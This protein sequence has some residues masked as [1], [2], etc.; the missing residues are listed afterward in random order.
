MRKISYIVLAFM[1][2][3]GL[4]GCHVTINDLTTSSSVIDY[5]DA[6]KY[7]TIHER[8]SVDQVDSLDVNWV[9]GH[10]YILYSD[11][12]TIEVH[13]NINNKQVEGVYYVDDRTLHIQPCPAGKVQ[14]EAIDKDITI[15]IPQDFVIDAI[16][17]SGVTNDV[18]V[19]HVCVNELEVENVSGTINIYEADVNAAKIET[20]SGNCYMVGSDIKKLEA[21]S[22]SGKID[23]KLETEVPVCVEFETV[24]GSKAIGINYTQVDDTD[25]CE[26]GSRIMKVNTVSADLEVSLR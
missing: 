14:G 7:E 21:D 13:E 1:M 15:E 9:N 3:I 11:V 6:D 23:M 8:I 16:D 19:E 4:S 26:E 12:E 2:L 5:D 22:V 20:V 17:L 24:S 25:A 10:V 18:N